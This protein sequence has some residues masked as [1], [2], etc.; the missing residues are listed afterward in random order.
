M[1]AADRPQ[2]QLQYVTQRV[3]LL[4]GL[5]TL[6]GCR[7]LDG[8]PYD[9]NTQT[10]SPSKC[11]L[12]VRERTFMTYR[13]GIEPVNAV[14]SLRDVARVLLETHTEQNRWNACPSPRVPIFDGHCPSIVIRLSRS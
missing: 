8:C 3:A 6:D 12:N 14:F 5:Q 13:R 7:L 10:T 1:Y 9:D 2:P 4:L 11:G